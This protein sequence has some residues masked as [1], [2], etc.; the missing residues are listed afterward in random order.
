[1]N[2][3]I[4]AALML[5]SLLVGLISLIAIIGLMRRLWIPT[6]KRA[7]L[8]IVASFVLFGVGGALLPAPASDQSVDRET[9]KPVR[10]NEMQDVPK[11][12][13]GLAPKPSPDA[14][15]TRLA[16]AEQRERLAR[17]RQI[18]EQRRNAARSRRSN[19]GVPA[20][21]DAH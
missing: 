20:M 6:R 12:T 19:S 14:P 2:E 8:A 1:M 13:A 21:Y 11:A 7:A 9:A 15:V 4:G 17:Q 16:E 10:P 5:L 18:E 3:D